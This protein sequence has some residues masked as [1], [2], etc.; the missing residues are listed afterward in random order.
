MRRSL[1]GLTA[2]LLAAALLPAAAVGQESK[3]KIGGT[4]YTK[5][6]WG[7][8]RFD[9]S[10]YNFTTVPGEG[11]GDNGQGSEV[12]LLLNARLSKEVAMAARIHSRFSQNQWT[13]F[14][15]FGGGIDPDGD[16]SFGPCVGGDC[17]EF[18][19]RSNQY[20]KLRG[21]TVTLT[22]GYSWIDSATIGA[23]DWG[24]FDPFVIGRIRYID[25]DNGAGLLFQ[26]TAAER[27][28]AWDVARISLPRLWAGPNFN[29]GSYNVQDAAYGLQAKWNVNPAFDFALIYEWVNDIEV[30]ARDLD[31]DDGRETRN[32]FEN[33]VL[34]ARFGLHLM[35]SKLDVR[36]AFYDADA[37]STPAAGAPADFF[38]ISG[39]SPVPAGEP[40]DQTWKLNLDLNDPFGVGLSFNLE[41]F[42]IGAEY[43]SMM[44]ARRESDV[45][46]TEGSD[47]A[48]A[49]PG[50]NNGAFGVF[51]GNESR[52]GFGG[53]QGNAQQVA[54]INVDNEFTDFD[55]P[56]AESVIGWKGFTLVPT[57]ST[58]ALDL[59]GEISFIDYNT[60][61]QAWDDPSRP[62][63]SSLFP[64]HESDAGIN[65]FRNAYAPFQDRETTIALVRF[66]YLVEA[67]KGVELFGKFKLI[68]ETD[69]RM[70]EA[71]FLPYLAGDCPGGGVACAN[72][73]RAYNAGGNSTADLYGNPPVITVNGVTGYQWKPFDSLSDDD[74]DMDY[75][76][77]QLGAGY[78]ITDDLYATIAWERYEVDLAD[79]NTAFQAYQLHEL[80]S[81]EHE[82]DKLIITAKY[83][84]AGAEIG[85]NY[86]YN[87]GSFDPDFGGGFVVQF[88]NADDARNV[89]V[90]EGTPGFRGRFG[91]WNSLVRRDFDQQRL[92]AFLKVQF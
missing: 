70:T 85:F 6:L 4:T 80:A 45:L 20:V 23:S 92:K 67:G 33:T 86:E 29:T 51:G 91:G 78:Q 21:V 49:F 35:D 28:F 27:R 89:G 1:A 73:A 72:R 24:M 31:P 44:A 77:I 12:E 69:D 74:R 75:Q 9:G 32:R 10:L 14:G 40:S 55:E 79:G 36:G 3:L 84:L 66:K 15:G 7:T 81:G 90:R 88:A 61:W 8:E 64:N 26:G 39:F 47:G 83:I 25:R 46:L 60:N 63:N 52:I 37:E 48:Y 68:D 34:G 76:M 5:W 50:P 16:G 53:W 71:R 82:K 59:A 54:T 19:S 18:D 22:P 13:N 57:F 41:A 38:G 62:I 30:D 43:V 17:G 11:F 2:G 87:T 58:G 65:S 42:D 56:M